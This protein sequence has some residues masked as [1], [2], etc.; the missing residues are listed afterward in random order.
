MN[1]FRLS[2]LGPFEASLDDG[3]LTGLR[4]SK[5]R[6]L[7][8]YLASRPGFP[9]LRET[10]ATLLWGEAT[11]EAA[12]LSLRVA[13]SSVRA[14]LG[15]VNHASTIPQLLE[16]TRH[17]VQLNV[18]PSRCWIDALEFDGLLAACTSHS[19]AAITR[20]PT[21][22]ER[23]SQAVALY[24]G[25]FLADLV[26]P[27]SPTFDE[28]R[29]LQQERYHR[30]TLTA[31][32]HMAE[33]YLAVG[34]YSAA[35]DAARRQLELE[36]WHEAAHRLL[37]RSLAL[38]GQRNAALAQYEAAERILANELRAEPEAETRAVY[39]QIRS[40]APAIVASP[41][42]ARPGKP[43]PTALTPF[44]GREQELRRIGDLLSD[45]ACRLL[46]LLGPGGIGKTRLAQEAAARFGSLFPDGACFVSLNFVETAE[47]L[48][49]V[50]AE[51]L[52]IPLARAEAAAVSSLAA[53]LRRKVMLLVLDDCQPAAAV[54]GWIVNLMQSAPGVKLIVVSHQRLNV[55]GEW[56][57]RVEGLTY[58]SA[59]G[60][61]SQEGDE[62]PITNAQGQMCD[63]IDLFVACARRNAVDWRL[64]PD[65][66]ACVTRIVELVHGMPLAIELAAA[67]LPVLS[68][69]EIASEIQ[70][71]LDFLATW[72]ANVPERQR[73]LRAVYR[74]VRSLLTPAEHA[75]FTRLAIFPGAFD[76][77]AA[78]TIAGTPL[79]M[80]AALADKSLLMRVPNGKG[81]P[82]FLLHAV[83]RQYAREEL[84]LLPDEAAAIAA[85]HASYFLSFLAEQ[86]P[87]LQDAQQLA[88]LTAIAAQIANVRQAWKWAVDNGEIEL[89]HQTW[90]ALFMFYNV[91]SWFREGEA[92]FAGL[93]TMLHARH[94]FHGDAGRP[95]LGIA[96]ASQAWFSHQLGHVA[97]ADEMMRLSLDT[98]C[99]RPP[100]EALAFVLSR[101]S[102]VAF[103]RGEIEDARRLC[104]ESLDLYCTLD[105]RVGMTTM[106]GFLGR[107]ALEQGRHG[108]AQRHSLASLDLARC[109]GDRWRS[110]HPLSNL[111]AVATARGDYDRAHGLLH[112]ALAI[113]QEHGDLRGVAATHL[114]LGDLEAARGSFTAAGQHFSQAMRMFARLGQHQGV[115]SALLKSA[116]ALGSAG[117]TEQGLLLLALLRNQ[118]EQLQ[119][120]RTEIERH[121]GMLFGQISAARLA[122]VRLEAQTM[123]LDTAIQQ[124]SVNGG[125]DC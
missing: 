35:Q 66:A 113:R 102:I 88:A 26:F 24:R 85:R 6:G 44:V 82:R 80:L 69:A 89:L 100:T 87:A 13:L 18:D 17:H 98:L 33:Y 28:W 39:A 30:Q 75:A 107:L 53:D 103:Q 65:E 36:P 91:R 119:R 49:T 97:K 83:L 79:T 43:V 14:A 27:D 106:H 94:E 15:S 38:D 60:A 72:S 45:P 51:A 70:G 62:L 34:Q 125:S 21:C 101:Q 9:H 40:G 124:F 46:A 71:N 61:S 76:R 84:A 29:V 74:Q 37:M 7:L 52:Q 56:M 12:R 5:G 3:P 32:G 90:Q 48:S 86:T 120:D 63:A 8:A 77:I 20:C 105:D 41:L 117:Q 112:E 1:Q 93:A 115:M 116:I 10:L 54:V 11:D 25:D 59:C 96:W 64:G 108:E 47:A 92:A 99:D 122:A 68:C 4:S 114:D 31:L 104:Q 55:R 109:R 50:V 123:T 16:A 81:N 121:Y 73:S 58:D 22:I 118:P 110:A 95:L 78:E 57:V 111:A 2:L 67:W 19:H 23:L 42:P